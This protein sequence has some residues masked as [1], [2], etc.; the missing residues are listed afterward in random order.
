MPASRSASGS[1]KAGQPRCSDSMP[2]ITNSPSRRP[3]PISPRPT[4]SSRWRPPTTIAARA[5]QPGQPP[6]SDFDKTL[7][8]RTSPSAAATASVRMLALAR[9]RLSYST[10]AGGRR[11][12]DRQRC[13]PRSGRSWPRGSRSRASPGRR[14]G[15]AV[16]SPSRI[17]V[18]MARSARCQG[19]LLVSPGKALT[20]ELRELS[21]TADPATR[22]TRPA[23]RCLPGPRRRARHDRDGSSRPI[24]SYRRICA[25]ALFA[26]RATGPA[27]RLGGG[28]SQG[29][30]PSPRSRR[31]R[32]RGSL[33][34]AEG[35]KPGDL[36][37]TAGVQKMESWGWPCGRGRIADEGP[38]PVGMGDQAPRLRPGS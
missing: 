16:V 5:D 13:R 23:S 28:S 34:V 9:N 7:S 25:A 8:S 26:L 36:A 12:G 15:E 1:S 17:G 32:S 11:R 33:V 20:A 21:P 6:P 30:R 14:P 29:V 38:Q 4:P 18:A 27:G 10:L 35:L 19:D 22:P 31:A 37:V 3:R 24:R 2:K